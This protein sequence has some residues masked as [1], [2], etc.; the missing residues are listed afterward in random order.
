MQSETFF[1]HYKNLPDRVSKRKF[2]YEIVRSCEI[3]PT[4]F[5]GWLH[6]KRV[7]RLAQKVIA[8]L[9]Q[10]PQAILFPLLE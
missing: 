8:N 6:R 3:E 7:P 1:Q 9:M 10:Q 4:T 2:R 5:Y